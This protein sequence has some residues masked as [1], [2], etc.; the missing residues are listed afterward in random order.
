MSGP[1]GRCIRKRPMLRTDTDSG[2][3]VPQLPLE[4]VTMEILSR[5]PVKSLLRFRSVCKAWRSVISDDLSLVGSHLQHQPQASSLLVFPVLMCGRP[6]HDDHHRYAAEKEKQRSCSSM[7]FYR[8]EP[9]PLAK[10]VSLVH[11][12][13]GMAPMQRCPFVPHDV[14]AHCDGLVLV[15]TRE[16]KAFGLGRDPRSG[17]YKAA[18]YFHREV[19]VVATG[20]DELTTGMEVFTIGTDRRWRE[21]ATQPPYPVIPGRTATSFKGSLLWTV[22][23][24]YLGVGATAPGFLRLSLEDET[25]G[26]TPPPPCHPRLNY[27]SSTLSELRGELCVGRTLEPNILEMWMSEDAVRPRWER[28]YAIRD[29]VQPPYLPHPVAASDERIVFHDL[30]GSDSDHSD[31][32]VCDYSFRTQAFKRIVKMHRLRGYHHERP[33]A[34]IAAAAQIFVIPYRENLLQLNNY[35]VQ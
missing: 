31:V 4:I 1:D 26:V 34:G 3:T 30:Q 9:S 2:R 13:D 19:L 22:D 33:G 25:F 11:A 14:L 18:R 29:A 27:F 10:A 23:E 6:D 24:A 17:A 12:V 20:W 28:R 5:L 16:R 15:A 35:I 21:V 7:A 32:F 8:W